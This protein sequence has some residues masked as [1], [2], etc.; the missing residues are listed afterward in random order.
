MAALTVEVGRTQS[1]DMQSL[2]ARVLVA[3][4]RAERLTATLP[5][6]SPEHAAAERACAQLRDLVADLSNSGVVD[7]MNGADA[8]LPEAELALGQP[9][10]DA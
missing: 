3:W 4:R 7:S 5:P 6:G 2:V 8:R 9:L 10:R 1:N